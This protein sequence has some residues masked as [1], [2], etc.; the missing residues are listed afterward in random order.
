MRLFFITF[1]LCFCSILCF[2]Q[3]DIKTCTLYDCI[4][5]AIENN[6]ELKI[7]K[8]NLITAKTNTV[9]AK[10]DYYP[11]I[12]AQ[13]NTFEIASGDN[14]TMDESTTVG[15]TL[16]L[17]DTGLR[18]LSVSSAV[19]SEKKSQKD[20]Y[21]TFQTVIYN[22][23]GNYFEVL[24]N[25]EL[26]S[27]AQSS[28]NY[29]EELEK[30]TNAQIELGDA[31]PVDILSIQSQ[32]ANARVNLLTA[33]NDVKNSL[34]LLQ[35]SMG[36]FAKSDFAIANESIE[37]TREISALDDYL[38]T[39]L[40]NRPDVEG[41]N[42]AVKSAKD[43]KKLAD[44]EL[45]PQLHVD[46]EYYKYI[47]SDTKDKDEARIMGYI[48]F[49][50]FDGFKSQANIDARNMQLENTKENLLLLEKTIN[51]QISNTYANLLSSKERINASNL[52][53]VSAQ[54]NREVQT[55]KYQTELATN[56]DV[57]NAQMQLDTA[58]ENSINARYDY[59]VNLIELDYQ[60]GVIGVDYE[61]K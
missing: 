47:D 53:F 55:E 13:N 17:F 57:L 26:L 22:V 50:I 40:D 36:L 24:R 16:K 10:S 15:A 2:A 43:N 32:L 61:I 33:K 45:L 30:Q 4:N 27:V 44:R 34:V 23:S 54:K 48:T 21:R 51:T 41:Y 49:N 14:K 60:T 20:L 19:N 5:M 18:E 37:D 52:G 29:Y 31:A 12:N 28:V 35:N 39:A 56:L 7:A 9:I 6:S 25:K 3:E 46:G 8:N 58:A 59:K 1:L 11:S 42:F 38:K